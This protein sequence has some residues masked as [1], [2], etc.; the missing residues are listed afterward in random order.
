MSWRTQGLPSLT[1]RKSLTWTPLGSQPAILKPSVT[2]EGTGD[3]PKCSEPACPPSLS[4]CRGHKR[5]SQVTA[6]PGIRPAWNLLTVGLAALCSTWQG[7]TA[8]QRHELKAM[9]FPGFQPVL[10]RAA[11][12]LGLPVVREEDYLGLH[13]EQEPLRWATDTASV[14]RK[15]GVWRLEAVAKRPHTGNG[16]PWVVLRQGSAWLSEP[17]QL[18]ERPLD[19]LWIA[20]PQTSQN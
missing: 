12:L 10:L 5:P 2:P 20:A 9:Q 8:K 13:R 15:R 4:G 3:R 16:L 1:A 19:S 18:T 11:L 17:L 6:G 14:P 7:H